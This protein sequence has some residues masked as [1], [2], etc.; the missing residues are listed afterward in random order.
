M[1]LLGDNFEIYGNEIVFRRQTV[2]FLSEKAPGALR[3]DAAHALRWYEPN[4][5]TYSSA[6][7][8]AAFDEGH[9]E[10]YEKG[11]L[12]AEP[13]TLEELRREREK[14]R[15]LYA[16]IADL[17]KKIDS[18]AP[19]ETPLPF[20]AWVAIRVGTRNWAVAGRLTQKMKDRGIEKAI[21]QASMTFLKE[22]WEADPTRASAEPT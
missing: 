22:Q 12:E 14:N 1:K 7:L 9:T 15:E 6:D 3:E 11:L 19:A 10:G 18:L 17:L 13:E 20:H 2:G 21:P 16:H 8:D 4:L 5:E